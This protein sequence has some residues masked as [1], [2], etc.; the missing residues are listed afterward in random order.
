VST[1]ELDRVYD[2]NGTRYDVT[3]PAATAFLEWLTAH[4]LTIKTDD[5]VS[6]GPRDDDKMPRS[7][8]DRGLT[9]LKAERPQVFAQM[10]LA[11]VAVNANV[12]GNGSGRGRR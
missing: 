11:I 3:E 2:G 5:D 7:W 10:M 9:W 6:F 12:T 4:G 8:A 1:D